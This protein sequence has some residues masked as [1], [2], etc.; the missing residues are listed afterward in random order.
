M[1]AVHTTTTIQRHQRRLYDRIHLVINLVRIGTH[2]I[3]R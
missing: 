2:R 1:L 3:C